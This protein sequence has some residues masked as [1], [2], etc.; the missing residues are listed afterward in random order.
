MPVKI[1]NCEYIE[2]LECWCIHS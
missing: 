2:L 1:A